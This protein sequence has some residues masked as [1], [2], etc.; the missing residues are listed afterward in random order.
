M[1]TS[2]RCNCRSIR[3]SRGGTGKA[4]LVYH[5]QWLMIGLHCKWPSQHVGVELLASEYDG[6]ELSFYVCL[7]G[8]SVCEA[9][10]G[11]CNWLAIL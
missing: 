3:W 8:L 11:V 9:L 4:L 5:F 2:Y 7:P 6:K 10:A 1:V